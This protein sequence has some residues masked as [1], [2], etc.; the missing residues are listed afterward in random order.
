MFRDELKEATDAVHMRLHHHPVLSPLTSRDVTMDDYSRA[1]A[2]FHGIYGPMEEALSKWP[3]S[4]T[5][6]PRTPFIGI[7]LQD[8]GEYRYL[9]SWASD[10]ADI[11]NSNA[12][13]GAYYVLDGAQHGGRAMIDGLVR[14]LGLDAPTGCRFMSCSDFDAD[15]EWQAL[16]EL[17]EFRAAK[18]QARRH[19]LDGAARTFGAIERW[20]HL[21]DGADSQSA[22]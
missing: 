12:A 7:D 14:R 4:R 8:L 16:I 13:L 10:V 9:E 17:I 22:A 18:Q 19:M 3:E 21:F 2:G 20:L 5:R 6:T 15:G 11:R 1:L